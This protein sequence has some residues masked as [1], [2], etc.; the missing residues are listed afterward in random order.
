MTKRHRARPVGA[1]QRLPRP[2]DFIDAAGDPKALREL[3]MRVQYPALFE[4]PVDGQMPEQPDDKE[5]DMTPPNTSS[6]DVTD[7]TQPDEHPAPGTKHQRREHAED[8]YGICELCEKRMLKRSKS[9]HLKRNCRVAQ[10]LRTKLPN[11]DQDLAHVEA[12]IVKA[13]DESGPVVTIDPLQAERIR[14]TI[15]GPVAVEQMV[16]AAIGP[17]GPTIADL[18]QENGITDEDLLV[19]LEMV[20][21]VI[22]PRSFPMVTEWVALTRKLIEVN[23]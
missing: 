20:C 10:F 18:I 5:Q 4:K 13:I 16:E 19:M 8:E 1:A 11:E 2:G 12:A 3:E 9:W 7:L 17:V 14:D 6:K 21:P 22:K 15:L 23:R